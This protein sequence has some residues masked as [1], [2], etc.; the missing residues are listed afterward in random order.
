VTALLCRKLAKGEIDIALIQEPWVY[1]GRI[2]GLHNT[3][4]TLL[5]DPAFL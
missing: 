2:R 3:R 5:L 1:G 4:G